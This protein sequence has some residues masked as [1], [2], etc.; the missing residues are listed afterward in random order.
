[1]YLQERER[2]Q[3]GRRRPTSLLD[4]DGTDDPTHGEQEGSAYHGYYRQHMYHPLLIFDGDTDQL[5]TAVLRPG[6]VHASRG[7][8][9]VLKRV[10]R[11]LVARAA[12]AGRR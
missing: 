8:V 5:I 12:R 4:L 1:M 6:N 11:V 2:S 7:V 10:V 9:A 3:A